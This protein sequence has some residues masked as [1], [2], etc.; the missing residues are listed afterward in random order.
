[1]KFSDIK[2]PGK[3]MCKLYYRIINSNSGYMKNLIDT[4]PKR[5]LEIAWGST[6]GERLNLE[7]PKTLN[8][9]IQWLEAYTDTSLWPVY[10]DKY[11]VREYVREQGLEGILTECYGVW[12]NVDDINFDLLPN[13]FVLKGTHDC[14][15]AIIIKD[16][17]NDFDKDDIRR[18]LRESLSKRYGYEYCEPHYTKIKPRIMA[19]ELLYNDQEAFSSSL[20]D[21][22]FWCF[23]GKAEC[24]FVGYDRHIENGE[25]HAI[26][27]LYSIDWQPLRD[28]LSYEN[29]L[30]LK[31]LVPKPS[32][33]KDMVRIAEKL[34]RDLPEIRVDLYCINDKIYFGELTM[35]SA[36]GRMIYFTDE[37]Q[38][39]LGAL[40]KL[41]KMSNS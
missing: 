4:N 39:E 16:K 28:K 26:F 27:D 34:S 6:F 30:Q 19:E 38:H 5:A 17:N 14:A 3:L 7:A 31:G 36:S 13:S 21:Y 12:D 33:L 2:H 40:V 29:R 8:E 35:S 9:K 20:I 1:M 18:K 32:R 23:N 22:K 10:A 41:P 11:A 15:S 25:S 37:F 24:I